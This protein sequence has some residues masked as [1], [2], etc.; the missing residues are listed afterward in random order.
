MT[1]FM[2]NLSNTPTAVKVGVLGA[3]AVVV[4]FFLQSRNASAGQSAQQP[5]Q[6]ASSNSPYQMVGNTPILPTG[7]N[8]I[9]NPTSGDLVAYQGAPPSS[10]GN[11]PPTNTG[12]S[13]PYN[14]GVRP[15]GTGHYD[16]SAPGGVPVWS[17]T[18]IQSKL[19]KRDPYGS[20]IELAGGPIIGGSNYSS[21]SG[22][23][24]SD[25][26]Y[27]L[28]GGGFINAYDLNNQSLGQLAQ[29]GDYYMHMQGQTQ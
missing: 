12:I 1:S 18:N 28:V 4:F 21:N 29:Y 17:G 22:F 23:T 8:P 24:G 20:Q 14:A 6:A 15:R 27:P 3:A 5:T 13:W 7:V 26:W 9:Y 19:L 2:E 25:I 16:T 11:V 10:G